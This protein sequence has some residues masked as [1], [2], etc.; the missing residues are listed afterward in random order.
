MLRVRVDCE[1]VGGVGLLYSLFSS[2]KPSPNQA[3][4]P[5]PVT[6]KAHPCPSSP[7]MILLG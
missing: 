3:P 7:S 2:W 4:V 1:L 6:S 5:F